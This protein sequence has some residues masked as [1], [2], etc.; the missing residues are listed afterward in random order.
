MMEVEPRVVEHKGS[1]GIGGDTWLMY[2]YDFDTRDEAQ[3]ILDAHRDGAENYEQAIAIAAWN[4]RG[5]DG[6]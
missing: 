1:F 4:E 3:S 6:R 2:E 5:D